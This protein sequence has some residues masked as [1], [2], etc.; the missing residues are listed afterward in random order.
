MGRL[1]GDLLERTFNFALAIL[2]IA[3]DLPQSTNG[4]VLGKQVVRSGTSVGANLREA[5]YATTDLEFSHK[6]NIALKEASETEYWLLLCQHADLLGGEAL[7]ELVRET[8]ELIRILNTI[9][10][11]TRNRQAND[12]TPD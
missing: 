6:C 1:Y 10:K 12:K 2:N 11:K 8:N 9:V 5:N 7:E 3:D 4:W